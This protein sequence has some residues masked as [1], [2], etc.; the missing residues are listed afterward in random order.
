MHKANMFAIS[1]ATKQTYLFPT[2]MPSQV[3][4]DANVVEVRQLNLLVKPWV[5]RPRKKNFFY[6]LFITSKISKLQKV[7]NLSRRRLGPCRVNL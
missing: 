5:K 3:A 6:W 7:D 1:I 4:M 2:N